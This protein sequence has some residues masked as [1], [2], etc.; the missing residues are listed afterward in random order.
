MKRDYCKKCRGKLRY[1]EGVYYLGDIWHSRCAPDISEEKLFRK[2]KMK[3]AK[4]S[5]VIYNVMCPNRFNNQGCKISF[6]KS[7]N[8]RSNLCPNCRRFNSKKNEGR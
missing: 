6:N 4:P 8:S 3:E 7:E 2:T 5:I 1:I